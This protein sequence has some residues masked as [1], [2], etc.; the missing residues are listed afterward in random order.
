MLDIFLF[1]TIKLTMNIVYNF[2]IRLFTFLLFS[3]SFDSNSL[4]SSFSPLTSDFPEPLPFFRPLQCH[5]SKD[6]LSCDCFCL[7]FHVFPPILC[8]PFDSWVCH[9]LPS[10]YSTDS[11]RSTLGTFWETRHCSELV[12]LPYFCTCRCRMYLI[13]VVPDLNADL[14]PLSSLYQFFT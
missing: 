1:P 8:G 13:S 10:S 6:C 4:V 12:S 5:H 14:N 2:L 7:S 11:C 3:H 9:F